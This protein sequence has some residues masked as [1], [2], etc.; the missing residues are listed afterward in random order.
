VPDPKPKRGWFAAHLQQTLPGQ[1]AQPTDGTAVNRA[2]PAAP[3]ALLRSLK[4]IAGDLGHAG[5]QAVGGG[6]ESLGD[7]PLA[8][9]PRGVVHLPESVKQM[10]KQAGDVVA[11]AP[12]Q[13]SDAGYREAGK[14]VAPW[15]LPYGKLSHAAEAGVTAVAP[16]LTEAGRLM[17]ALRAEGG[18]TLTAKGE[19][20]KGSGYA[21]ARPELTAHVSSEA[22]M[23]AFLARPDVKQAVAEGAHY[24]KYTD[25]QTGVTE[26]NV[27]DVVPHQHEAQALGKQRGEKAIGH[28]ADGAY[29]GDI[30]VKG[31]PVP[32]ARALA[33]SMQRNE[34]MA[35]VS[36]IPAAQG[37][38]LAAAYE[39]LPAHD[40]AAKGAYEAL[41]NEVAGQLDQIK[42]AGY[43]VEYVDHDPYKT[44][45]EMMDDVRDNKTLKV[46]KTQG[47]DAHPYMTA[48]QNTAFRAVHDFIAHAG[49]G[50]GF[51]AVGEEN[52][53]RA[54]AATLS[55]EAL[56]ALMTETRG[57]NSWV[58]FGP[59]SHLPASERPFA[60]QKAALFPE[61]LLG[62]YNVTPGE[63]V[64]GR[65]AAG[66]AITNRS[67]TVRDLL[68]PSPPIVASEGE[69]AVAMD[70]AGNPITN[71]GRTVP[72]VHPYD[73]IPEYKAPRP[74]RGQVAASPDTGLIPGRPG[75]PQMRNNQNRLQ[76]FEDQARSESWNAAHNDAPAAPEKVTAATFRDPATGKV[77][78]GI[79]HADA[80][81]K[82]KAAGVKEGFLQENMGFST[83]TR[84]HITRKE[85]VEVAR[86]NNSLKASRVT[87]ERIKDQNNVGMLAEDFSNGQLGQPPIP[88]PW[89]PTSRGVFDRSVAPIQGTAPI[90][91]RMAVRMPRAEPSELASAI[92]D[93]K[94]VERGLQADV[95]KGLPLGG[96]R[97]YEGAPVKASIDE[98][99]GPFS[100]H[101]W[102]LAR[103]SASI[104]S[105]THLEIPTATGLLYGRRQGL[106]SLAEIKAA[107]QA[108][109]PDEPGLWGT[110]GTYANYKRAVANDAQIPASAG[111]GER[112][113][114]WYTQGNEGGAPGADIAIDKHEGR[115]L[116]QLAAT[117]RKIKPL[118]KELGLTN[119][120][121]PRADVVPIVNGLDYTA[122][123]S[124][125]RRIADRMGLASPQQ[126]QAGRWIGGGELTG[127]K[128][129]PTGDF[130]QTL[131]DVL[132][133]TALVRGLP[134]DPGSLQGLWQRLAQ[135]QDIAAPVYG[136]NPLSRLYSGQGRLF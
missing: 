74:Y 100:F 22:E 53:A 66:N 45:Q 84:P 41:N 34:P 17:T 123:S 109:Y 50:H 29:Q 118:L 56:P 25:P 48:D 96:D 121:G 135:G 125:Y 110:A 35:T 99:G 33:Q 75:A 132:L 120:A 136:N 77:Y 83:S 27:T 31:A 126:A 106:Q 1:F 37:K 108:M 122:L 62:D 113:V 105:P 3:G 127:L 38:R 12:T 114:P 23:R 30:R 43:K 5:R 115:R 40:P 26:L 107:H 15:I 85:A 18:A 6:I 130:T 7:I 64:V 57:Q 102:N 10:L 88:G 9:T 103:G 90:D 61:H 104:Q 63:Q 16:K 11:G 21:V 91:P 124:P 69:R 134:T 117:D 39:K 24:G 47:G 119:V 98:M 36:K 92:A 44:S 19:A 82:A 60:T 87:P 116:L 112:K 8:L 128:S 42:K 2:T 13:P 133:H 86:A 101:D 4:G 73:E 97:W 59:N 58:N 70:A 89:H 65:D 54:H 67:R 80:V 76:S 78:S 94:V 95:E 32:G 81:D 55:R 20:F 129:Q 51:N 52:A 79:N 111:T 72:A 71:R 93:S 49:G 131:E 28:L 46:F 14:T 68:P